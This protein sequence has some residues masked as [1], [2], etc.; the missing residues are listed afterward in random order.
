MSEN[1]K[2]K[3]ESM[4]QYRLKTPKWA[5]TVGQGDPP[6]SYK[7]FVDGELVAEIPFGGV[8]EASSQTT[9][10]KDYN[11]GKVKID[12]ILQGLADN[13]QLEHLPKQST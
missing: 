10:M 13:G 2:M 4:E 6:T 1:A 12:D 3:V 5:K 11:P 9:N 7:H 8:V